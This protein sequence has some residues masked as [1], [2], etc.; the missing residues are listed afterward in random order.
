MDQFRRLTGRRGRFV[1]ALI[2]WGHEVLTLWGLTHVN[3]KIDYVILDVG[4]RGAKPLAD[5]S[6]SGSRKS[7]RYRLFLGHG[8]IPPEK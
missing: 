4:C 6:A 2:N 8:R 5:S 7:F 3:I 1:V